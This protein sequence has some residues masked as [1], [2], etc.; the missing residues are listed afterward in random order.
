MLECIRCHR[1]YELGQYRGD[2]VLV[3]S[4]KGI[5]MSEYCYVK[6][7]Q[8]EGAFIN[9]V[10]V[11]INDFIGDDID[12]DIALHRYNISISEYHHILHSE[13]IREMLFSKE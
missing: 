5:D 13:A 7:V 10:I 3:Y 6:I 2:S 12:I 11:N 8:E 4:L 1:I 9:G